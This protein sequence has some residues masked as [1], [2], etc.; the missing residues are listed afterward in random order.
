VIAATNTELHDSIEFGI[1]T[2]INAEGQMSNVPATSLL[3]TGTNYMIHNKTVAQS[4]LLFHSLIEF[5]DITAC[6]GGTPNDNIPQLCEY[7]DNSQYKIGTKGF[8][9]IVLTGPSAVD[10]SYQIT[11][12][13]NSGGFVTFTVHI[14]PH[15]NT[16]SGYTPNTIK[17]DMNVQNWQYSVIT[18]KVALIT[19]MQNDGDIDATCTA[20]ESSTSNSKK[21]APQTYFTWTTTINDGMLAT[22][23]IVGCRLITETELEAQLGSSS[24]KDP[25]YSDNQGAAVIFGFSLAGSNDIVWDPTFG[26]KNTGSKSGSNFVVPN[27]YIIIMTM[28][29]M[30]LFISVF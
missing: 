2:Q 7:V 5:N 1:A 11:T 10:G 29:I 15:Q 19:E 17:F 18:N 27:N 28:M 26:V 9:E 6:I 16:T 24:P 21:V 14:A 23:G 12:A 20:F 4:R 13:E 25:S 30:S 3:M 22:S 8:S